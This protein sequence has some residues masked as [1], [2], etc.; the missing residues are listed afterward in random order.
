MGSTRATARFAGLL[1][2]LF[3]LLAILGYMYVPSMYVVS[4][5][6]AATARKITEGPL[7][8]RAG[9]LAALACHVLF[10]WLALTLY[11]LFR[12]VDRGQARLLVMLVCVGA[13][14]EIVNLVHRFAPLLL[15]SGADYLLV[16]PRHQLEALALGSLRLGN[17]LGQLLTAFWGLWLL[18]FGILVRRSG[19]IPKWIGSLL[20]VG[21][22]GYLAQSV[23]SILWPAYAH[24][25]FNVTLPLVAPGGLLVA[26][27]CSLEREENEDVMARFLDAQPAFSPLP[28]AGLLEDPVAAS[29]TGSM[30]SSP[31][32]RCCFDCRARA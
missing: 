28:L 15:L 20:I 3:A 16:F 11:R 22:F 27:T 24:T 17:L 8:Y 14:A 13:T 6:A 5:D 2:L 7:L 32:R 19:F 12:D 1:Y 29:V 9:I 18:P 26:I 25:V 30:K 23:T 4:G 21:C 10:V 31:S